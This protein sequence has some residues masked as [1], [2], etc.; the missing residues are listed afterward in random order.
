M[1][2]S[3]DLLPW[4][5]PYFHAG[6]KENSYLSSSIDQSGAGIAKTVLDNLAVMG[7]KTEI[8]FG[9]YRSLRADGGIFNA[10]LSYHLLQQFWGPHPYLSR[11]EGRF[12]ESGARAGCASPDR[13]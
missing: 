6:E 3:T 2:C 11:R 8:I 9:A 1:N 5:G 12:C 4:D 7:V 10:Y 13:Y